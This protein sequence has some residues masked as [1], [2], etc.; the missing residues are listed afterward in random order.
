MM[1]ISK[2]SRFF[3]CLGICLF[4]GISGRVAS[5]DGIGSSDGLKLKRGVMCERI[6]GVIPVHISVAF[7]INTGQLSCFTSFS[8]IRENTYVLHKWYRR[9]T[10]VTRKKLTLKA[11]RWS[12]YSSIQ[13]READKGPWRVEIIDANDHFLQILRFSVTD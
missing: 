5:D 13:L 12:T 10:L 6:E 8:D 3:F 9:D 11:P 4:L 7:S 1:I 2:P